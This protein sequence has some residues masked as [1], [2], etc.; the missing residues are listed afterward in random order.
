MKKSFFMRM[1]VTML[2]VVMNSLT[3]LPAL[4]SIYLLAG[5]ANNFEK[6]IYYF[7]VSENV[8]TFVL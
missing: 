8:T 2:F 5:L 4:H 7:V 3:L 6:G 1:V